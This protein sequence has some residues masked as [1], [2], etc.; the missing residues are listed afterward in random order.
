M[1]RSINALFIVSFC[2]VSS[3]SAFAQKGKKAP[4]P[5]EPVPVASA[6]TLTPSATKKA[7][8]TTT[9]RSFEDSAE[10]A[11]T[12]KELYPL[13]KPKQSIKE[14]ADQQYT[15]LSRGFTKVDMDSAQ[16]Y[17]MAMTNLDTNA[18]EKIIFDIYRKNLSAKELKGYLNFLKTAEGKKI[19]E[20][21]P[22]LQRSQAEVNGYA[23][24]TLNTNLAP[25]RQK[26]NEMMKKEQP[27]RDS[28]KGPDGK[29]TL[30]PNPGMDPNRMRMRDSV[31]KARQEE[32]TKS[33][34]GK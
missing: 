7:P 5:V 17:K 11:K 33:S 14:I 21:M 18:G 15:R 13:V 8:A 6:P 24:K 22:Q 34:G 25:I 31:M 19:V 12:F 4:T 30:S 3:V 9:P 20:V 32:M 1:S 23:L 27:P 29:M 16:M 26:Q 28:V 2:F 10:F